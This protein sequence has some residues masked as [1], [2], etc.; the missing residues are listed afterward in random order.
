MKR[1][2]RD[3]NTTNNTQINGHGSENIDRPL[4]RL[5]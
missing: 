1:L 5:C 4:I 3:I 2:G